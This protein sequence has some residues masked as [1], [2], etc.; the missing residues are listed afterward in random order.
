MDLTKMFASDQAWED[1]FQFVKANLG[2]MAEFQGNW[3]VGCT[4]RHCLTLRDSINMVN[5]NVYVYSGLKLDED[6]RA[7]KYR[8][9]R[10]GPRCSTPS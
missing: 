7:S 9:C 4:L 6:N 1:A 8:R 2:R 5:D 10:S 3:A